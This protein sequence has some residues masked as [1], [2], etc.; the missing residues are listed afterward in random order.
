MANACPGFAHLGFE[1]M[2]LSLG[3]DELDLSETYHQSNQRGK[4]LSKHMWAFATLL[5][6]GDTRL[7]QHMLLC[8]Q[9][10]RVT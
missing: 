6:L 3:Q 2:G 10:R 4:P 9:G 1:G 5:A 7:P 8:S